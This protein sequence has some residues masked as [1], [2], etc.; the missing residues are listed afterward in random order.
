MAML[1]YDYGVKTG[2]LIYTILV[3]I[4]I[5]LLYF[6]PDSLCYLKCIIIYYDLTFKIQIF[7]FI[8]LISWDFLY[9]V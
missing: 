2:H 4:F 9:L 3:F 7:I 5:I 1:G 8:L 6:P